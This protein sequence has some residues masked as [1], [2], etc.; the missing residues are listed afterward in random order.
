MC[1][2]KSK[3]KIVEEFQ[4]WLNIYYTR[5]RVDIQKQIAL[6]FSRCGVEN[7]VYLVSNVAV[8]TGRT[9]PWGRDTVPFN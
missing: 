5:Y 3:R 7:L 6:I 1:E 4:D 8:A 2:E 9:M